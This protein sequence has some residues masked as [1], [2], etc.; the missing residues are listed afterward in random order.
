MI[1]MSHEHL[2]VNQLLMLAS[3]QMIKRHGVD[4]IFPLVFAI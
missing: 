2:H 4:T 1:T 3:A